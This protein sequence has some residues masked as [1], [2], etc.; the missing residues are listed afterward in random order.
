MHLVIV[1]LILIVW[2]V[3]GIKEALTPSAPPIENLDE[4]IKHLQ[5]LPDQKARQKYLK[6]R[7]QGD[8]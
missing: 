2:S 1:I 6:S 8:K 3:I 7:K 5:S 4:H